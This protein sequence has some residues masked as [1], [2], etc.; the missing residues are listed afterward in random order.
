MPVIHKYLRVH[1]IITNTVFLRSDATVT[2]FFTAHFCVATIQGWHLFIEKPSDINDG[3][4]NAV[5]LGKELYN[6][7]IPS[8]SLLIVILNYSH[9]YCEVHYTYH[10]KWVQ[11]LTKYH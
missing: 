1:A 2:I 11:Y 4:M 5:S 8:T 6:T 3:W 7:N 10:H 9:T